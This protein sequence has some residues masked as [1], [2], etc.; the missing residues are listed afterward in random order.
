MAID[1]QGLPLPCAPAQRVF[2]IPQ[3]AKKNAIPF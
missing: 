3:I 1:S 2:R